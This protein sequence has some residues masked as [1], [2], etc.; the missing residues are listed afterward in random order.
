MRCAEVEGCTMRYLD[1]RLERRRAR[2]LEAHLEVCPRCRRSYAE[3]VELAAVFHAEAKL[4]LG[5]DLVEAVMGEIADQA[6]SRPR[7]VR[8][9]P[10]IRPLG[11]AALAA[12]LVALLG[13]AW[14]WSAATAAAG[15]T[16]AVAEALQGLRTGLEAWWQGVGAAAEGSLGALSR[17]LG[18]ALEGVGAGSDFGLV[19]RSTPIALL[20]ALAALGCLALV[21]GWRRTIDQEWKR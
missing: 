7:A 1:G 12:A 6:G 5:A 18:S 21:R 3:E 20:T 19:G 2:L 9:P 10:A 17:A 11:L 14:L 16:R 13:G 8:E 4:G 15:P